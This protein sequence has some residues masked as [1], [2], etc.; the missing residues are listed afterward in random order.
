MLKRVISLAHELS[1][2]HS[3][4]SR[5]YFLTLY[6]C[7]GLLP[8]LITFVGD[9]ALQIPFIVIAVLTGLRLFLYPHLRDG[10]F[11]EIKKPYFMF[12]VAFFL[13]LSVHALWGAFHDSAQLRLIQ[14][15]LVVLLLAMVLGHFHSIHEDINTSGLI[16]CLLIGILAGLLFVIIVTMG[17]YLFFIQEWDISNRVNKFFHIYKIN[18]GLEV[19]S[20]LVFIAG[21]GVRHR[22]STFYFTLILVL[23]TW[24]LSFH[25]VGSYLSPKGWS[26]ALHVDSETVQ[27][28]LPAA[29]LVFLATYRFPRLMTDLVFGSICFVLLS[30]PWFFQFWYE[31]ATRSTLPKLQ[32]LLVRAEIWDGV[33]RKVLENPFFGYGIDSVRYLDHVTIAHTYYKPTSLWHPHNMFLQ[34]WLDIGL[35]GILV[36]CGLLFFGWRAVGSL[37]FSK[38]PPVLASI[39]ML[40]LFCMV[41]HS[42]WQTWSMA[43]IATLSI[44]V[45]IM[46]KTWQQD[47][48]RALMDS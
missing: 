32:K 4:T 11:S 15:P 45:F 2:G 5:L 22:I 26:V 16:R 10:F 42:F 47:S 17:E 24:L 23:F 31:I 1:G 44:I 12:L 48:E 19:I 38:R 9:K 33:S 6:I 18:R 29:M 30:A 21:F 7:I 28:G 8:A 14:K 27:F 35:P 39:V 36:V 43:L 40:S 25:V 3:S 37:E 46:I 41:T 20:T 13:L 34:I